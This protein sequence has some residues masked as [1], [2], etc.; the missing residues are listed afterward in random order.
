MD[1][2]SGSATVAAVASAPS[3]FSTNGGAAFV[4]F[5][6]GVWSYSSEGWMAGFWV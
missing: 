5:L 1:S 4:N 3:H 2:A 6:V